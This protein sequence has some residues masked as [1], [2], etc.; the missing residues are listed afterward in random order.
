MTRNSPVPGR[1]CTKHFLLNMFL[2]FVLQMIFLLAYT[3]SI[4]IFITI[5][6]FNF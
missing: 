4:Y 2:H 1:F 6:S 5:V 3:S